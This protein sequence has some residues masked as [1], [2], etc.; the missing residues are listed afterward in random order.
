M[1]HLVALCVGH[2]RQI[3]GRIEGGAVSVGGVSEHSYNTGLARL[4]QSQLAARGVSSFI[5]ESYEGSGYTS[6]QK[7]LGEHLKAKGATLAIEL[8]FNSSENDSATGHEW[9]FWASS[10]KGK[11]LAGYL[12]FSHREKLPTLKARGTKPKGNGD[13]GGEFLRFTHCPSVIAEPF[14]GSNPLDWGL[15]DKD[16]EQ[17]ALAS[18][19]GII[20]YLAVN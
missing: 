8:H 7:W 13:R 19:E 9:L 6:A 17:F 10:V 16:K 4:I 15:A 12:D 5:V 2:S 20:D 11:K 1:S 14:F 18:A 3:H